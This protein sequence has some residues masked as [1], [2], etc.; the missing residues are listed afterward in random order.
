MKKALKDDP[1]VYQYDELYDDMEKKREDT[2]E[3]QKGEKKPKYI[4]TLLKTAERRQREF[5][6]R[7]ERDVQKEREA[8]GD[9][10]KDKEAFVTGAY[11][12][13]MEELEKAKEDERRKDEID[14]NNDINYNFYFKLKSKRLIH[15]INRVIIPNF[16]S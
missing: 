8:E 9:M 13:K 4:G 10:F 12:K 14:G 11:R 5:E 15:Y 16:Q 7:Q 1:T 2:K 3:K 6:E